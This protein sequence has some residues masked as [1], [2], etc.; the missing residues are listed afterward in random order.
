LV[1]F[2]KLFPAIWLLA[3]LWVPRVLGATVP[4]ILDPGA[5]PREKYGAS[6]LEAVL[7]TTGFRVPK[8]AR[9][10]AGTRGSTIFA[11]YSGLPEFSAGETEA[12]QL[13]RSG[14]NWLVL[15]SDPSGVLYGCLELARRASAAKTLP[16]RIEVS[17]HP[18]FPIR[19]TNLLWEKGGTTTGPWRP[20]CFLGFLTAR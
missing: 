18:A 2:A 12:F 10:I 5:T 11:A 15:G 1:K 14:S 7:N 4:V 16:E 6:R 19:G 13:R 17:D 8:L 3:M 9:I 20:R